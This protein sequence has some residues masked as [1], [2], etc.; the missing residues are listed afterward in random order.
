MVGSLVS[1]L[2]DPEDD[3][4]LEKFVNKIFKDQ[5]YLFVNNEG[6]RI[7]AY[8]SACR[9]NFETTHVEHNRETVCPTC[10]AK[11][12]EKNAKYGKKKLML[13]TCIYWFEKSKENPDMII[14][15]GLYVTK[16]YIN[17][18]HPTIKYQLIA[19]YTFDKNEAK[20]YKES[21]YSGAH[22]T[23]SIY[24]FNTGWLANKELHFSLDNLNEYTQ[25]TIYQY[26]SCTDPCIS[27]VRLIDIY[28]KYPLVESLY[29]IG[30]NEIVESKIYDYKKTYGAI[31]WRANT[32]WG[33]LKL[34]R[35]ELKEIQEEGIKVTPE[36][37]K[38]Y[39]LSKKY[40]PRLKAKEVNLI[41][42]R[43]TQGYQK[44][45]GLLNIAKSVSL[46][47]A[48]NYIEKQ[49]QKYKTHYYDRENVARTWRDYMSDCEALEL[50]I[51]NEYFL[52]PKDLYKAHQETIKQVKYK[53]NKELNMKIENRAKILEKYVFRYNGLLIRPV[54]NQKELIKEGEQLKHCVGGYAK[55]YANAV[56]N[57]FV[58]RKLEEEDKPYYTVEIRGE[59]II[60]VRGYK[61]KAPEE[62]VKSF[63]DVF[64]KEILKKNKR[65]G[66]A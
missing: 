26:N 20:M 33:M 31:N 42:I 47:K 24:D 30:L 9:G 36:F 61:N 60:Q 8:C 40:K 65:K 43:Y 13:E 45:D 25:G 57:I 51:K 12:T 41:K 64:K 27:I 19:I 62:V 7:E 1:G 34:T 4:K 15:Q 54:V 55:N 5:E 11:L 38:L 6:Y 53:E 37:L 35:G 66:V 58:I 49:Y 28:R 18:K 48:E 16:N 39:Q 52:F 10:G 59:K 14:C 17:Y 22:E 29:K 50:D 21:Y 46:R 32:I 23:C 2:S 3:Y 56:T 44:L 63:V